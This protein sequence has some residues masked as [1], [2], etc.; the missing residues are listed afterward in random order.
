MVSLPV[1]AVTIGLNPSAYSVREDAGSVSVTLS[2]LAGTL[3]LDVI[4]TLITMNSTAMCESLK[5]F[6]N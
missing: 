6:K 4:V 1:S 3:D 5:T 2:V